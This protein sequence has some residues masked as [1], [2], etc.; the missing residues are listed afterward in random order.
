MADY[1]IRGSLAKL[2]SDRVNI[3]GVV[4]K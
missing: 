2:D 3:L 4:V 1:L